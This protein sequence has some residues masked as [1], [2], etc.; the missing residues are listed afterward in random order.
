MGKLK[1]KIAV[2]TGGSSGIGLETVKMLAKE[3]ASVVVGYHNGQERAE[4]LIALLDGLFR[5]YIPKTQSELD[6]LLE[7]YVRLENNLT[8]NK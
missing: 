3:V 4:K 2:V 1:D 7:I 5:L 6:M 8:V